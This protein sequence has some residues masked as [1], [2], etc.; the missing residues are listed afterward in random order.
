MFAV[1]S[2]LGVEQ[3]VSELRKLEDK[4]LAR[5]VNDM[6]DLRPL[7]LSA[8]RFEAELY[9]QAACSGTHRGTAKVLGLLNSARIVKICGR[10][11]DER[12]HT[13]D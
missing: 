12:S 3:W 13:K 9:R 5:C 11:L 10:F 6:S 4:N 8:Y 2:I 7:T 1:E